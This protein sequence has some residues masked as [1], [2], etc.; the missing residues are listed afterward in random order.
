MAANNSYTQQALANDPNFQLRVR[1][2]L[3]AVAWQVLDE[4]EATADHEQ[5]AAY[6]RNVINNVQFN[7]VAVAPWLVTRP[8]LMLFETSY[9]FPAAAVV[10]AA[11]DADI[12]SQLL[13]DWS[14]LA[15]V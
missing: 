7:A 8:N 13:T 11:G 4:P 10:T 9:S 14:H 15:G 3:A 1:N 5:R 6:A 12:Q 2:A